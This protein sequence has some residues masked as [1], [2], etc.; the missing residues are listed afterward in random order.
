MR[1]KV[2]LLMPNRYMYEKYFLDY[3]EARDFYIN[4]NNAIAFYAYNKKAHCVQLV[5][6]KS[7]KE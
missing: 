1:H 7:I 5:D 3:E 6:A 4:T 2:I